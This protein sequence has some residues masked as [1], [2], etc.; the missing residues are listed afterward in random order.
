[1]R[2]L[3]K[4][5]GASGAAATAAAV[6]SRRP[7]LDGGVEDISDDDSSSTVGRRRGLFQERPIGT[8][9]AKAAAS[10]DI[11]IQREAATMAAALKSLSETAIERAGIDLWKAKDVRETGKA[12]KWCKNEM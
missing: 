10:T 3:D 6:R 5:S 12:E 8:K 11:A 7:L 1:M 4:L 9:A 2:K